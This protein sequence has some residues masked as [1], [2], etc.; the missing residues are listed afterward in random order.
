[1]QAEKIDPAIKGAITARW[2]VSRNGLLS[3]FEDEIESKEENMGEEADIS[4]Q[5]VECFNYRIMLF[6]LKTTGRLNLS[7]LEK[8]VVVA[9]LRE[10]VL[11][12]IISVFLSTLRLKPTASSIKS[13]THAKCN[14]NRKYSKDRPMR[15]RRKIASRINRG[16]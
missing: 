4:L 16:S 5:K 9:S 15:G 10:H 13:S 14:T 3:V 11:T 7:N 2:I 6:V 8:Q 12:R 1:M